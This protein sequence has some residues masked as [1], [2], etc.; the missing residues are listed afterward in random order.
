MLAELISPKSIGAPPSVESSSFNQ[1]SAHLDTGGNF[2]LF[3]GAEQW[4][5]GLSEGVSNIWQMVMNLPDM[6]NKEHETAD[7]ALK[8]VTGLIKKSGAEDVSGV[9]MSSIAIQ[10]GL[11]RNKT[12]LHHYPE[13]NSGFLWTMFGKAPHA[14][15]ALDMLSVNTAFAGYGDLDLPALWRAVEEDLRQAGIKEVTDGLQ[16]FRAEFEKATGSKL[17]TVIDSLGTESGFVITLDNERQTT[18]PIPPNGLQI[19]EPGLMIIMQV[20]DD[21][22]FNMVEQLVMKEDSLKSQVAKVDKEGLK[23]RTLQLPMP[24]P[25]PFRPSIARL[26]NYLLIATSDS[27]ILEILAVKEGQK[28]GLKT[29]D[30]FKKLAQDMPA[31]GNQWMF[32]S[33]RYGEIITQFQVGAMKAS[34]Q[35]PEEVL[36]SLGKMMS[37]GV[38]YGYTISANTPD[39][40][41]TTGKGYF[42]MRLAIMAPSVAMPAVLAAI[43]I[44]NFVKARSQAQSQ[45]C[46]ANLKQLDGAKE[47]WALENKKKTGDECRM[48]DLVPTYIQSEPRCP[49]DA[50]SY[51]PNPIGQNPQ[52]AHSNLSGHRLPP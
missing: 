34:N 20:K 50:T 7:K 36:S 30:E 19:P 29:A 44:P 40:W 5:K 13:K 10:K 47:Q 11:Y 32:V 42:D 2:Y 9:G 15:T 23:M 12:I 45:A 18:L 52:C 26:G 28:P 31:E 43:A 14:I 37:S 49:I 6:R 39:G 4:M 27:M 38:V 48:S 8:L 35:I 21:V 25:L 46:I 3:F 24:F 33:K 22:I 16:E 17:D 1:V 41:I 51:I